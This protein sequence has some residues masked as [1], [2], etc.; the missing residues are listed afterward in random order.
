[1]K[2]SN[3]IIVL[4]LCL[5]SLLSF[6]LAENVLGK[7]VGVT[8]GDS[9][10]L[11]T[12]SLT[13]IKVRLDGIDCPEKSQA[14]GMKAKQFTSDLAYGKNITLH[15]TGI[16]KYGRTL[17][18]IEL[19][20]G[21]ILNEELIKAGYAWHYKKYNKEKKLAQFENDAR[22]AKL[23]LWQDSDPVA[24]WDFRRGKRSNI[25]PGTTEKSNDNSSRTVEV[26]SVLICNSSSSYAFH[27]FKCSG[28]S[29]CKSEIIKISTIEAKNKSRRACGICW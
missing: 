15:K 4:F 23:G 17:G 25:H 22:L 27:K 12:D 10:T 11:L 26:D 7:V 19:P 9:I 5:F 2:L 3:S 18:V 29:R 21:R 20:D 1:M 24:P 13:Q 8:D 16:D 28:L 14:F 6:Q